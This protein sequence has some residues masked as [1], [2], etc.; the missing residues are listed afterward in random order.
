MLGLWDG[1]RVVELL[2]GR[3]QCNGCLYEYDTDM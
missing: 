1:M 3:I 2:K